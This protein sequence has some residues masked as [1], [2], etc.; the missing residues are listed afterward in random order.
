MYTHLLPAVVLRLTVHFTQS[1]QSNVI[2]GGMLGKHGSEVQ[3]HT[4]KCLFSSIFC[5]SS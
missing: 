2:S 1:Q 3:I 4:F 5:L